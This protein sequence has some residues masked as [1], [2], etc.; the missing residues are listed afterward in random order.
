MISRSKL[1]FLFLAGFLLG[2]PAAILAQE[3]LKDFT[4]TG[5]IK[6]MDNGEILIFYS[7]A[8]ESIS[9]KEGKFNFKGKIAGPTMATIAKS[10]DWRDEKNITRL[11]IEPGEMTLSLEVDK[12]ESAKLV[13]SKSQAE[14]DQL[15][16][17]Q[18]PISEKYAKELAALKATSEKYQKAAANK[19]SE[20]ELNA[21]KEEDNLAR[22]ALVPFYDESREVIKDFIKAN[23]DSYVSISNM[24]FLVGDLT[25]Q[26]SEK[27]FNGLSEELRN[28]EIGKEVAIEIADRKSGSPGS[29]ATDFNTVD[30]NGNPLG[31]KD[32][33]GKYLLIDFWASWCVPCRK[34][35]PHLLELYAKYHDKGLEVLGISDDDRNPEAWKKAV[36]KD[37]VGVWHHVLRGLKWE[38]R[39][40]SKE[41]DVTVGYGINSLPTKILIDPDGIIIGRYGSG[42]ED[43]DAM[44]RKLAEIFEGPKDGINFFHG[45]L[46]ELKAKA[47]AENK[48]IFVDAYTTWCG[49]CKWMSKNTFPDKAVGDFYNENFISYKFDMEK[50]EGIQFARDYEVRA[51]PTLL[52]ITGD[53]KLLHRLSGALDAKQFIE[54]G[55]TAL[56]PEKRWSG[57]EEKYKAGERSPEFIRNYLLAASAA[58]VDAKEA[59]DWYFY[60]QSD[61]ELLSLENYEI[62]TALVRD[63]SHRAFKFLIVNEDKFNALLPEGNAG[64]F[65]S[66][67]FYYDIMMAQ[68]KGEEAHQKAISS[69]K[70]SGFKGADK[71]LASMALNDLLRNKEKNWN[72]IVEVATNYFNKYAQDDSRMRNQL[73]WMVYEAEDVTDKK[74]LKKALK[75][76]KESINIESGYANNDT[77]AALL[78][79][80]GMNDKAVKAA[81]KAIEIGKAEGTD[82]KGTTELIEKYMGTK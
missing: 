32:F 67:I 8:P 35:S 73:A 29:P 68:R 41:H 40:P 16:A 53:G 79:K 62:I 9:I 52:F 55:E 38:G 60:T 2:T 25:Y 11:F 26:E 64:D 42:G 22:E 10:Q 5:T 33:R 66:Q 13:G 80:L 71:T 54:L 30:I 31:L 65:I 48:P 51:F 59:T 19:A 78:F 1:V 24:R 75:W 81:E 37:G 4:I 57:I 23:P 21:I 12:F 17:M 28:S 56:N 72:Q 44:D 69:M 20:E 63:P 14:A 6:G 61:E 77:Y 3:S 27:M 7:T 45:T 15:E 47:Q 46:D 74:T 82:T 18:K 50:G 43:D 34:G 58:M 76:A 49:P 39:M 36:E 70:A